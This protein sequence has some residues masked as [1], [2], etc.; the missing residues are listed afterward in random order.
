VAF[1]RKKISVI[2]AGQVGATCALMLA[3][4]GVG[5]VVLL[6]DEFGVRALVDDLARLGL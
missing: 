6:E 2:G 5:D 4:R 1:R 3:S